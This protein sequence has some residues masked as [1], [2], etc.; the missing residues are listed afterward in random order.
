MKTRLR[1]ALPAALTHLIASV[2]VALA[3]S[4]L[5]LLV[6]FPHPFDE[7]LGGRHLFFLLISVDLVCGPLLTLIVFNRA[8]P[9]LELWRDIGSV[10]ILQFCALIYGFWSIALVRPVYIAFE[11]DRFRVVRLVDVVPGKLDETPEALRNF[12]L[13]GPRM[14]GVNVPK[15]GEPDFEDSVRLSLEDEYPA[16]RPALWVPI[17]EQNKA[18]I[19]SLRPL[20]ELRKRNLG[21]QE[22]IDQYLDRLASQENQLGYLPMVIGEHDNWVL[23]LDRGSVEI[24]GYLPLTGW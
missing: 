6:W 16:Y 5:V 22:I 7:L 14:I 20:S 2:L 4:A 13:A 17:A 24:V 3:A 21:R 9:K 10:V 23:L 11:A 1:E 12:S 15:P 8:K 18:L 19:G